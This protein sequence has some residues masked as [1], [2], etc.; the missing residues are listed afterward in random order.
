MK[1][2]PW[3][4]V[5]VLLWSPCSQAQVPQ[6][7]YVTEGARSSERLEQTVDLWIDAPG[8][9]Q[10]SARAPDGMRFSGADGR[11]TTEGQLWTGFA[12]QQSSQVLKVYFDLALLGQGEHALN[13]QLTLEGA[14]G[15]LGLPLD[16]DYFI[17]P[18]NTG[19]VWVQKAGADR[20]SVPA[21]QWFLL[22]PQDA[23]FHGERA[24]F[25]S[26]QFYRSLGAVSGLAPQESELW[27]PAPLLE[28]GAGDHGLALLKIRGPSQGG[29]LV[30]RANPHIRIGTQWF[31]AGQELQ[32]VRGSQHSVIVTVPPLSAGVHEISGSL[33]ALLPPSKEHGE[34]WAF[35]QGHKAATLIQIDRSWFDHNQQTVQVHSDVD[36]LLWLPDGRIRQVHGQ[37]TIQVETEGLDVLIPL[38][39]P[40]K[41]L[42][43]GFPLAEGVLW[44]V[45]EPATGGQQEF[46]LPIILWDQGLS[47]RLAAR[48]QWWFWDATATRQ[49][50]KGQLGPIA[51]ETSPGKLTFSGMSPQVHKVGGWQWWENQEARKGAYRKGGW[52]WS[53]DLP[54]ESS[55]NPS[56]SLQYG[57][58]HWQVRIAQEDIKLKFTHDTWALG[59]SLGS[60]SLWLEFRPHLRLEMN[61]RRVQV[62]W[63]HQEGQSVTF[64]LDAETHLQVQ[65]KSGLWEAYLKTGAG[66][67]W[68]LRGKHPASKGA[69][70]SV[71]KGAAQRKNELVLLEIEQELGLVLS[72]W[73]TLYVEGACLTTLELD[74]HGYTLDV[75]YGTGVVLSPLP[76]VLASFGWNNTI[77]WHWK[78]GVA[79]PL[80]GRKTLPGFE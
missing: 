68:G 17:L 34:L 40:S 74:N 75:R 22:E 65:L 19:E 48:S 51:V 38:S 56:L 52:L 66:G 30:L 67:E 41:P 35:W 47:W 80:V 44:S 14:Q 43:T 54:R 3:L 60:R 1:R 73:C 42:W 53:I 79:V 27:W 4:I 13:L 45:K 39:D 37:A 5:L 70:I 20:L 29:E 2:L 32:S 6:I 64:E 26:Q 69:W 16:P 15:I 72:P 63:K 9:W 76:Q 21:G 49:V 11:F 24:I 78:A 62:A 8:L 58:E 71:T 28:L 23:L 57:G 59:A 46:V 50:F 55:Q 25:L 33:Q 61:P 36:S 7:K 12:G 18:L 10:L 31:M 77:G